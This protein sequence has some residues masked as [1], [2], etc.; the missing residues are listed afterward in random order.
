MTKKKHQDKVSSMEILSDP[1]IP[2]RSNPDFFKRLLDKVETLPKAPRSR[3]SVGSPKEYHLLQSKS[4]SAP[5]SL[6]GTKLNMLSIL[7]K[8]RKT[9]EMVYLEVNLSRKVLGFELIPRNQCKRILDQLGDLGLVNI[10]KTP[11]SYYFLTEKAD[12][13]L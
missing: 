4:P 8:A 2:D 7:G 10:S 9:L 3:K 13:Y 12:P 6:Q 5:K 11:Q 1:K